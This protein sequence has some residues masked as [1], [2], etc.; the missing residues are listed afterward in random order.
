MPDRGRGRGRGHANRG[1]SRGRPYSKGPHSAVSFSPNTSSQ[2]EEA[3]DSLSPSRAQLPPNVN[4]SEHDHDTSIQEPSLLPGMSSSPITPSTQESDSIITTSSNNVNAISGNPSPVTGQETPGVG[5][6]DIREE[7]PPK[8]P[9]SPPSLDLVLLELREI[10]L[11]VSEIKEIKQQISKLDKIG[12]T[13]ESLSDKLTGVMNRTSEIDIAVQTNTARIREYDDLFSTMQST[14]G[15]HENS[16][17]K[18]KSFKEDFSKTKDKAV[19][20]MNSLISIQKDQVDSF[21]ANASN[22]S[23]NI[24]AEV[25]L[26]IKQNAASMQRQS[27]FQTLKTQAF[28]SRNNLVLVGLPEDA[29]KDTPAVVK[30]FLSNTLK[31]KNV[32]FD[33]AYRIGSAPSDSGSSYARPVLVHF[34][35]LPHRNKVWRKRTSSPGENEEQKVRIHAD[36]PKK[37]R[38]D[39]QALYK[40]ARAAN[41]SDKYQ[42]ARVQDYSLEI[43]GQIFLPS[44][45]E[46]LP[47]D[48]RP[49]TLAAPRSDSALAFFSKHS[50]FSNHHPSVFFVDGQKFNSMEQ[51]LA[52]RR[53]QLSDQP[54]LIQKASQA[55]D[56]VQAKFILS[57]LREDNVQ[58]WDE[59]VQATALEGLEAKFRQNEAMRNYLCNTK[60]LVI[61]EASTNSRWGV[62]MTLEHKD[63]LDATKWSE[64]GNLLGRCLMKIRAIFAEESN[65]QVA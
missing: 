3:D 14:V 49:S 29:S 10:K 47:F 40:V 62:G 52:F 1:R 45:L 32:N 12:T 63:I 58:R 7:A 8:P 35:V 6:S 65:N 26:R 33:I 64:S 27:D 2:A 31:V 50:I 5:V 19:S 38:D 13:T 18:L 21:N 16:L 46:M 60:D 22:L 41:A 57:A 44:E 59:L 42:F 34:P 9:A 30:D 4:N 11:Q 54:S 24:L 37:L 20:D 61:G 23:K 36:L 56:P 48:I 39:I 15:K 43:D 28:N 17:S 25:D 55:T 53:A 51:F